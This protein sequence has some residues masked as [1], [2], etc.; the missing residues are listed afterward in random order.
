VLVEEF[1]GF[2]FLLLLVHLVIR[3]SRLQQSREWVSPVQ[4][5]GSHTVNHVDKCTYTLEPD[6][7]PGSGFKGLVVLGD[8][9]DLPYSPTSPALG[10]YDNDARYKAH[11]LFLSWKALDKLVYVQAERASLSGSEKIREW[12][13]M[14]ML[15]G[16]LSGRTLV[17]L[18]LTLRRRYDCTY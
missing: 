12:A 3:D 1:Y 14:L 18:C 10:E 4:A 2:P 15:L 17:R 5:T 9:I 11:Y 6:H 8:G 7:G 13:Q 16:T